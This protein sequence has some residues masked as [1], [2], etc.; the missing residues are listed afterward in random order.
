MTEEHYKYFRTMRHVA[1]V[2]LRN[3]AA[4]YGAVVNRR[5]PHPD[6]DA[7]D[8]ADVILA[9]AAREFVYAELLMIEAERELAQE[10]RLA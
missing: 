9:A 4:R 2:E 5:G 1:R 7:F 10:A 6:Q 3:A 8:C